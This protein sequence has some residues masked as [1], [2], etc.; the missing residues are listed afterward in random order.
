MDGEFAHPDIGIAAIAAT[1]IARFEHLPLALGMC[2]F[3]V[4]PVVGINVTRE[5]PTKDRHRRV[6]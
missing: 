1:P 4:V 6:F 5:A 3:N 2:R